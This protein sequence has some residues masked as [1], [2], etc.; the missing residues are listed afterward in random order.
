MNM[1]YGRVA[2]SMRDPKISEISTYII[3]L[4]RYYLLIIHDIMFQYHQYK[5]IY[6]MS[7]LSYILIVCQ[8]VVIYKN[9]WVS[10]A[11]FRFLI[12]SLIDKIKMLSYFPIIL[13]TEY[14]TWYLALF[15]RRS[16]HLEMPPSSNSQTNTMYSLVVHETW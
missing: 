15:Y 10:N 2:L 7:Y 13:D 1:S 8:T 5:M 4:M 16:Q 3:S 6:F 14:M 12:K 11:K 9:R